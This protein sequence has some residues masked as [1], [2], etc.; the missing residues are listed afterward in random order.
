M[1][2]E[3]DSFYTRGGLPAADIND[4]TPGFPSIRI[5]EIDGSTYTLVVG[6]PIGSPVNADGVMI[7]VSDAGQEDGFYSYTFT[8]AN[9]YD[10]AKRY[11]IRT[12]GGS[13][14]PS[15]ERYQVAQLEPPVSSSI[16]PADIAAIAEASAVTVWN[17]ATADH[18]TPGTTGDALS[19]IL[20]TVVQT[21]SDI[22][23][24]S[25]DVAQLSTDVGQ[26][27]SAITDLSLAMNDVLVM[28]DVITKYS[29]NR[30]R[31]DTIAKTL[32][33]YDDDCTTALRVFQL[34]D[35]T[36]TPSIESVCE[37]RPIAATDG[38]PVCS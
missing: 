7:V 19:D 33:V 14:I 5:W 38:N 15:G 17:E 20:T 28:V 12:D 24:L 35:S 37:R 4:V 1:P 32:T 26:I 18:T 10:E 22:N 3:I 8:E 30:T 2:T 6:S 25:N 27:G 34:L 13:S 16:D 23:Q 36:G 29:T 31:I 11:L 9:G 21:D